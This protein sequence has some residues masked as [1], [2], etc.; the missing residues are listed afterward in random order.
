MRRE[1][2]RDSPCGSEILELAVYE[3]GFT[4]MGL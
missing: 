4:R 1:L 2:L 3:G